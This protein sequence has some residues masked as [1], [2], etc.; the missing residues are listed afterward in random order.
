VLSFD[1]LATQSPEA[2]YRW[3][4][5]GKL[6]KS[7]E[8]IVIESGGSVAA[9]FRGLSFR[10][11]FWAVFVYNKQN[12]LMIYGDVRKKIMF[13]EKFFL[14]IRSGFLGLFEHFFKKSI[15]FYLQTSKII[16]F[17]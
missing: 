13:F 2:R 7:Q 9:L 8:D 1:I 10:V 5:A 12:K 11:A 17:I 6:Y 15:N 14:R 3:A 4:E 16:R